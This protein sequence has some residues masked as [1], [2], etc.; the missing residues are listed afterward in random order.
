MLRS[1]IIYLT[2]ISSLLLAGTSAFSYESGLE[3]LQQ[4]NDNRPVPWPWRLAQPFPWSDIQGIWKVEKDN[5]VSYFALKVINQKDTG[6]RVL[7][8]KQLDANSCKVIGEGA[9]FERDQM[10]L[11]Q[12]TDET[13]VTYRLSFTA[14][15]KEDSPQPPLV[16]DSSIDSVMVLSV[17][18]LDAD[19][20]KAQVNMQIMKVSDHLDQKSCMQNL[21]K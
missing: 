18:N 5:F 13:G 21:K 10:V 11:A 3:S 15:K 16:G 12:M 20:N 2:V 7:Q 19:S 14:F 17:A 4:I 8:V 1:L 9:G 6:E